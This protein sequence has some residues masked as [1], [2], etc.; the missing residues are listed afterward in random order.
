MFTLSLKYVHVHIVT[1][2]LLL[3]FFLSE[4]IFMFC[5]LV[6]QTGTVDDSRFREHCGDPTFHVLSVTCVSVL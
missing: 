2:A 3:C 1:F 6:T 5:K 4:T